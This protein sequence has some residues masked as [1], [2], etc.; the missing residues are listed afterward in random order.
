M[1]GATDRLGSQNM[2]HFGFSGFHGA[3]RMILNDTRT[4]W[5]VLRAALIILERMDW[6]LKHIVWGTGEADYNVWVKIVQSQYE[7]ASD[8]LDAAL[9][10]MQEKQLCGF[11]EDERGRWV[12]TLS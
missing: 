2:K 11:Y 1:P 10:Y 3:R 12:F 5:P 4:D 9:S 8:D 7:V 6:K